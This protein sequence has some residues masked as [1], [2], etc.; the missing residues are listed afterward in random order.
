MTNQKKAIITL[1]FDDGRIDTYR[2]AKELLETNNIPATINIA[3][4]YIEGKAGIGTNNPP[5]SKENVIEL[6]KTGLFEIAAHGDLHKNSFEDIYNG[7][8]KLSEWLDIDG[9]LGFASPG[10]EMTVDYINQ[11]QEKLK[12]I[13]LLYARTSHIHHKKRFQKIKVL[14]RKAARVTGSRLLYRMAYSD[15]SVKDGFAI[16]S[17]PIFK[18][19]SFEQI[20]CI[21]RLA[22][23]RKAFLTLMFHSVCRPDEVGAENIYSYDYDNF[24]KLIDYLVNL[25]QIGKIDILTTKKFLELEEN[26]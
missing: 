23:R 16:T 10:S 12:E 4:G 5:M 19:T 8:I 18:F 25:K 15:L 20:K 14:M 24:V 2:I 1:S 9:K 3:T 17:I 11:N 26:I 21:I 13:G 6:H 22:I 7:K